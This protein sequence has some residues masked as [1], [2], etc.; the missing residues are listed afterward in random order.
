[1]DSGVSFNVP[2][3]APEADSSR[4]PASDPNSRT[5]ELYAP[6]RRS[7]GPFLFM[8]VVGVALFLGWQSRGEQHLTAESGLGYLLGIVGSAM[9][10]LLLVYPLR[11]RLR[12]MRRMGATKHWF[13]LHMILGI[14]GPAIIMFHANFGLG[15]LNSRITLLAMLLVVG[16]GLIGR[17]IYSKIHFSLYGSRMNLV[18]LREITKDER[19][20][21][22]AILPFAPELQD[23]LRRYEQS[24]ITPPRTILHSVVRILLF[25]IRT[26]FARRATQ[27]IIKRG[28]KR[29]AAEVGWTRRERE[30][31]AREAREYL[32]G[33]FA[34]AHQVVGLGFYERMFAL[35]HVLHVP[36]FILLVI[37]AVMHVLAVHMY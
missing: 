36:L 25:G 30:E 27:G 6:P 23:R 5:A 9:M 10:L 26:W 4:Q 22:V 2:R 33:Y 3:Q 11:K 12:F 7:Y 8:L 20:H 1:M 15:S 18:E 37:T 17:Y 21:L 24:V 19:R 16:S 28:L 14:L 31:H 32:S 34:T 35:W 13:R 29:H